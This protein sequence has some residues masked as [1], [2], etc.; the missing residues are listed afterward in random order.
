MKILTYILTSL[1]FI[2][3]AAHF[4]R[5][6]INILALTSLIIPV[7]MFIKRPVIVRIIQIALILGAAEWVRATF[8]YVEIR[9]AVGEDYI[10]LIIILAFVTLFTLSSALLFQSKKMKTLYKIKK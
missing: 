1:S 7:L 10:R 6:D 5:A 2:F 9:K 3:L 4:S 8:E